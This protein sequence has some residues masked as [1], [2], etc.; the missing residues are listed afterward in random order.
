MAEQDG[1]NRRTEHKRGAVALA[2][3]VCWL[4]SGSIRASNH[5]DTPAV[6]ANPQANIG[7]IYAW[8]AT[9]GR[10][11]NL[12][13][14]IVGHSFS[15]KLSY[16]FHIDS[17][18]EFGKTAVTTQIVCRFPEP[19]VVD[20]RLG[21]VDRARGDASR[22]SGLEGARDRFR[23][24]AGLRDDPFFNNVKGTR[25]AYQ[26]AFAALKQGVTRDAAGC[27]GFDPTTAQ[28]ILYEWQ[29]TDGG[30]G[31]NFLAHW[32]TSA[33]VISVDLDAVNRGGRM[34]A[35]WGSTETAARRFDRLGRPLSKN[36][37]LGLTDADGVDDTLKEAWNRATPARAARFVADMEKSLAFYDGLD[38]ACGNQFLIDSK[39]DAAERYRPLA[40][41]LADDRLWVN[42][43][44]HTCTQLF[45]V[46]LASRDGRADLSGDCGGRTPTY[47]ASNTWRSLL[48]KGTVTGIDDGLDHDE[49]EPSTTEFPFLAPPDAQAIDH[50][51]PVK[52]NGRPYEAYKE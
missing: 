8:T 36:A 50:Y 32:T 9:D 35:V 28:K 41:L 39:A 40:L 22:A 48:V 23:V 5:L 46:E 16:V 13:M 47:N 27:P 12:V 33:L 37:L 52:G 4:W 10:H 30:P 11:L 45:A 3:L 2:F 7:D 44:S 43:A 14:D 21:N 15:D 20:C 24:F 17:G 1:L 49:H 6:I 31:K 38:G 34:L 29:H 18:P 19:A 42:T 26:V 51:K 25:A